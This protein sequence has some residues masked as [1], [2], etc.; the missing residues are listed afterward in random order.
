VNSIVFQELKLIKGLC[1]ELTDYPGS[2]FAFVLTDLNELQK[3]VDSILRLTSFF[4]SN[5]I[6]HNIFIT[7][8]SSK[9]QLDEFDSLRVYVWARSSAFGRNLYS[10]GF[11]FGLYLYFWFVRNSV[12]CGCILKVVCI[13]TG[14]KECFGFNPALCEL[15]GHFPCKG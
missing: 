15:G 14:A 13:F 9:C 11:V 7:R 6:A 8:G 3:L 2:G 4:Q 12:R 1:Y 5:E 10:K